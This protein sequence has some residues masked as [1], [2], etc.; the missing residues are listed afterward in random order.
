MTDDSEG[1]KN[2]G[3]VIV[4]HGSAQGISTV[5]SQL[6]SHHTLTSLDLTPET[7][8]HLGLG[9][10]GGTADCWL[11]TLCSRLQ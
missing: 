11:A 9:L 5:K 3:W 1:A 10:S 4:F 8:D 2:C 7:N 6:I